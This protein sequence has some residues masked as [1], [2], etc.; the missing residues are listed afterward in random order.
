MSKKNY[1]YYIHCEYKN[2]EDSEQ[3]CENLKDLLVCI[4]EA[5]V[6]EE[7]KIILTIEELCECGVHG[8]QC[9]K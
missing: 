5:K 1:S 9:S 4:G 8:G 7:K 6:M 3:I 2:S